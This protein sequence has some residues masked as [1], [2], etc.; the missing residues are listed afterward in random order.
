MIR[1]SLNLPVRRFAAL[2]G[3]PY[4]S[5][6]ALEVGWLPPTP[7]IVDRLLRHI[8]L[9]GAEPDTG[10]WRQF[11][12]HQCVR[13]TVFR[14]AASHFPLCLAAAG[15]LRSLFS[16]LVSGDPEL[17]HMR[18]TDLISALPP[19]R[20]DVRGDEELAHLLMLLIRR[21]LGDGA[22]SGK[23]PSRLLGFPELVKLAAWVLYD[24]DTF[25]SQRDAHRFPL[26]EPSKRTQKVLS[27]FP[28]KRKPETV[29]ELLSFLRPVGD[30]GLP[31]WVPSPFAALDLLLLLPENVHLDPLRP[32]T[33]AAVLALRDRRVRITAHAPSFFAEFPAVGFGGPYLLEETF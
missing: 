13:E 22:G 19:V 16:S 23:P 21:A 20:H 18:F 10:V 24:A 14:A 33:L 30:A 1:L 6:S 15:L 3:M 9:P 25:I 32:G 29:S 4:S 31:K 12:V 7:P 27:G 11:L 17:R 2:L 5:L 26:T 28:F 8:P